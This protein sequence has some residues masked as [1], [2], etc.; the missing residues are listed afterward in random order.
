[1]FGSSN[2]NT[3]TGSA[4]PSVAVDNFE[5]Y[6]GKSAQ[7]TGNITVQGSVRIDGTFSGII[8]SESDVVIGESGN[9]KANIFG[10]NV[11]VAGKVEGNIA[12]KGTLEIL[13]SSFI[14]GDVRCGKLTVETGAVLR[15]NVGGIEDA[16]APQ[17]ENTTAK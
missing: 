2:S 15:G 3:K 16:A 7:F 4:L 1:M 13:A 5:A 11:T 8:F 6:L 17:L 9:I 10:A 14:T 12:A